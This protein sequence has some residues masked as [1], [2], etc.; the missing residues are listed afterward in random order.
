MKRQ[1]SFLSRLQ[2]LAAGSYS[3]NNALW[4]VNEKSVHPMYRGKQRQVWESISM[5]GGR[6]VFLML[7]MNDLNINGLEA[8]AKS[9]RSW[10][11][12]SGKPIRRLKYIL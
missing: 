9:I 11:K 10:W 3:V 12:K 5:M 2:F 6:R 1:D 4:E 7:G 8:A